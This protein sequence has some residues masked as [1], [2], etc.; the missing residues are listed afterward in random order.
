PS[1]GR[2]SGSRSAATSS[3]RSWRGCWSARGSSATSTRSTSAT[4]RTRPRADRYSSSGRSQQARLAEY[5]S[6]SGRCR[7]RRAPIR[8]GGGTDPGA[9]HTTGGAAMKLTHVPIVVGDQDRALAFYSEVLGFE[10][11]ADYQQAG[12]PRWLTVGPKG[13]ALELILV[14]GEK[15]VDLGL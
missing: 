4:R 14:Q 6:L 3:R 5:R 11:R 13:Q 8:H 15:E 10:K 9:V 2:R 1:S 12:R 7:F